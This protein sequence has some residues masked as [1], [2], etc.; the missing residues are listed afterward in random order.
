MSVEHIL[1]NMDEIIDKSWG[2]PLSGGRVV[3]DTEK[4]RDLIDDIRI[5]LPAELRQSQAIV[6]DRAEILAAA[7]REGEAII[8]K[9]EERAKALISRE[10]VVRAAQAR[11][12]E[13]LTQAQMKSREI[14]QAAFGFSDDMLRGVEETMGKA[15][16]DVRAVRQDMRGKAKLN[17]KG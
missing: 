11:A 7:Q 17:S 8:R 2:L 14:R 1:N 10:E 3:V 9:A 13:I 4:I 6:A 16:A 15:L 5:N 12:S